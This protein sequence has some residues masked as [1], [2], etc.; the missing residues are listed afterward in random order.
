MLL[1]YYD[2]EKAFSYTM[3]RDRLFVFCVGLGGLD[4][5]L[6]VSTGCSAAGDKGVHSR[7]WQM[8]SET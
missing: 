7:E 6:L 1:R 8:F 2:C 4:K 3:G 5:M